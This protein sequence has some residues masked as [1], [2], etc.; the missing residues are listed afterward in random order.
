MLTNQPFYFSSI[1]SLTAGFGTIFNN[2]F[3]ER[4]N[5]DGTRKDRIKVPISYGPADKTI[6]MLQEHQGRIDDDVDI[7]II[8]PRLSFE[9]T[10]IEYANS[11]KTSSTIKNVYAPIDDLTFDALNDVSLINNTITITSHGLGTGRAVFYSDEGGTVV[12]GLTDATKYFV[13]RVDDDTIKLA[14]TESN[15]AAG[16]AIGFSALGNGTQKLNTFHVV[17]WNPVPYNVNYSLYLYT[18]YVDDGLQIIEQILPYFTPAYTFTRKDIEA[19]GVSKD[20]AINLNSVNQTDTYEGAVAEDR[21]IQWELTFTANTWIYPP[22][23]DAGIIK[24]VYVN[25]YDLDDTDEKL[26][27]T[28]VRVNPQTAN[29]DDNYTIET[30]ITDW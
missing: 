15:A 27:T 8:L 12:T 5:P 4:Y 10:G 2:I 22:L 28:T 25:F 29:R 21:I 17:Q 7:K 16:T 6:R 9:I 14:T 24:T 30:T 18:K 11:R 1:R 26:V 13:I 3:L 20:V 19:Y 23:S